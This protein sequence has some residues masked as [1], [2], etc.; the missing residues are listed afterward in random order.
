M[1]NED[2][3]DT[4]E[5]TNDYWIRHHRMPRTLAF[6]PGAAAEGPD[7]HRISRRRTT[8]CDEEVVNDEW[9]QSARRMKGQPWKGRTIFYKIQKVDKT[10][11]DEKFLQS[12]KMHSQG[13]YILFYYDQALET[14]E[15]A[16]MISIAGWKS[17]KLKRCTVN[18]L[19]AEC[20]SL[21][22]GIGSLHWHRFLLAEVFGLH[23]ELGRWEQQLAKFPF[24]A[25]TDS[26]SLYDTITKCRNNSSH[27]DDKR[28]AI[29][30]TILT[31]DLAN[32]QG[33]VRWAG[34]N[35]MISDALTKRMNP[36]FLRHIMKV[37]RWTLTEEGHK[38][39]TSQ[40]SKQSWADVNLLGQLTVD[41]IT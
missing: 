20:Q 17:Y 25:V 12:L 40:L 15:K 6:H 38:A 33:Q 35:N 19:S 23:L 22:H 28:T 9:N 34:G 26:K 24:V 21:L 36:C 29:D 14:S 18:T 7:L 3:Q 5:E 31:G 16:E 41:T 13:G 1:K 30:L 27:I 10:K 8:I 32:S 11:I 39:L 37:G 4:W 2:T